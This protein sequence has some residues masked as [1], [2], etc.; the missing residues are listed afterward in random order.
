[1]MLYLYEHYGGARLTRAELV[2][3]HAE[4]HGGFDDVLAKLGYHKSAR[5]VCGLGGGERS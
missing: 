1:V 5:R 3:Q 2:E 4:Q